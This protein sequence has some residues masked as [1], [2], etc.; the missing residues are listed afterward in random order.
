MG[1]LPYICLMGMYCPKGMVFA[2]FCSVWFLRECINVFVIS[3]PNKKE[4][5]ICKFKVDFQKSFCWCSNL[6]NDN[7]M[8]AYARS[9]N[10]SGK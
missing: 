2:P 5:T 7:I 3:I 8:S 1:I 10:G 6:S 4:R 9:E